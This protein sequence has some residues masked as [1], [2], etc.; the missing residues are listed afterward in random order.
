MIITN[1]KSIGVTDE[2]LEDMMR[3]NPLTEENVFGPLESSSKLDSI[4]LTANPGDKKY[5][6]GL[7]D[8]ELLDS[9]GW[10]AGIGATLISL[11]SLGMTKKDV[12][13]AIVSSVGWVIAVSAAIVLAAAGT[14]L[15]YRVSKYGAIEVKVTWTYTWGDN[16]MDYI[17]LLTDV[18]VYEV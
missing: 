1:L 12:A 15:H 9:L 10:G 5:N 3:I 17:W 7:I 16:A 14:A 2:D 4:G 18:D 13:V 8:K 11:A 6:Y